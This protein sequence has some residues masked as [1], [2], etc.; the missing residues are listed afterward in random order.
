MDGNVEVC[1]AEL[2]EMQ[3]FVVDFTMNVRG[4]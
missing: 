1:S 3:K 2:F 4:M